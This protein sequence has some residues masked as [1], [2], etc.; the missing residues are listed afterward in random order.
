M[1]LET[2]LSE[3]NSLTPEQAKEV[4][5]TLVQSIKTATATTPS[6]ICSSCGANRLVEPCKSHG[7]CGFMASPNH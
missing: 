5:I 6:V 7:P 1:D 4:L 3:I 2:I